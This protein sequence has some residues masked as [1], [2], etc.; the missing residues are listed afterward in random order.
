MKTAARI[1]LLLSFAT[2][3]QSALRERI[4]I[5]FDWKFKAGDHPGAE[6]VDY[7]DTNW[8]ALDVP[9]DW[10]IEGEYRED[11]PAGGRCGYLPTG[12]VWYRKEIDFSNDWKNRKVSVE[13]DSVY[14]NS[15]VWI[16]GIKLGTRPYGYVTFAYDL[17]PYLK[18]GK[19]ILAVRVDNE[20]QESGRWYTGTGI[21]GHVNL[22]V[23]GPVHVRRGG[24]FFRTLEASREKAVV[25]IDTEVIGDSKAEVIHQLFSPSGEKVAEGFQTLEV[26]NPK[27]WSVKT[28]YLYTLRTLV[29]S[30]GRLVD[31][32]DM[33]VG[34]RTLTFDNHSGFY[35]NGV[36]MKLKGVCE[37][38]TGGPLGGAIPEKILRERLL[39]LK[40]MGCNAIRTAHNPRTQDFYRLCSELGIMVMDEIFDGWHR[41]AA[42]DYG[43]RF[44]KDWWKT[45]VEEWVR[46]DRN[47]PCVVIY[48]IGN[49]TGR[50]DVNNI[51]GYIKKF[52]PTRPT[53]G[54]TVFEGVDIPGFN[55][56]GGLPG[57]ME[58]FHKKYPDK[59]CVRTEVPH[60]LQ[61]RGF[62]R[63]RTWWR[64]KGKPH[65]PIPDYGTKQI[66]FDGHPRY[67]SSYDNCA[68]RI[69]ARQ[70]WRETR[71]MPW[72]IGEFR[73]TG[74]DYLGEASFSGGQ[75]P[76]R[77]WNFG[78]ID[79]A[80]LPKDHYWFYKSQWTDQPMVH[81]LPHWTH[82][83]LKRGTIVPVVAYSNCEEVELFLNGKSLGRKTEDPQWLEFLWK[84][85]YEPGELKAVGY[86]DGKAVA[87]KIW[88][89][90]GPPVKLKLETNNSNL[91]PDRRDTATLTFSAIDADGNVTPWAMNRV[92]FKIEG[93]VKNLGF[94]NGDPVDVTPH[95][96]SHRNLFYG[97]GRG[98]F[99]SLG[100]DGP[101][102]IT[103]AAILGDTLFEKEEQ[104]A[105]DVQRI[106]LRG[107]RTMD[108]Y[109]IRYTLDGS[110]P[111][112]GKIYDGPFKIMDSAEVRA[113]V[114]RGGKPLIFLS[115]KFK[116][117]KKPRITDPRWDSSY[118]NEPAKKKGKK[119]KKSKS[120]KVKPFNGPF[121]KELIGQWKEG[122]KIFE[123]RADGGVYKGTGKSAQLVAYWWYDFPDDVF[124]IPGD[125]GSGEMRWKKSGDCSKLK[126]EIQKAQKLFIQKNG[127]KKRRTFI[128]IK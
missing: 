82:R 101:I 98:F 88:R 106:M 122:G 95:R 91:K 6:A 45:D 128:K 56:P 118:S 60:T 8:R 19:N 113:V 117:G 64:D 9:H 28:P 48:S 66:F 69:C 78:I 114:L 124:E 107:R 16:N 13:F 23:T 83:F 40:E 47:Y 4:N 75:W 18:P 53:T 121:D 76:A 2:V 111:M 94:E 44:F 12:I 57:A 112:N 74:F 87:K 62:Y 38:H 80:G 116:K 59:I 11:A 43:A 33:Q 92:E 32:V 22:L 30:R 29:K 15:T 73:W 103:A 86:N 17:T 79:L 119:G 24:I 110:N 50:K 72:V 39:L 37:H 67:S 5:D 99:Q 20:Q 109:T 55:G 89:T 70:S 97:Y 27:L 14:M 63:V 96:V 54:G 46:A 49:E 93:P 102:Q 85:P 10:S 26:S 41:K 36:P 35:L 115:Q 3:C 65:N 7:D 123:F 25:K 127:V 105:I 61:T 104:V 120:A 125:T 68:V 1:A 71:D 81:I 42:A 77:I 31:Q 108:A 34:I 100:K 126:L 51:S 90:A 84:V 52:D 21:F 58:E